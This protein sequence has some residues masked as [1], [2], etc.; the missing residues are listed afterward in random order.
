MVENVIS[1][2]EVKTGNV[3]SGAEVRVNVGPGS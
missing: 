3:T 2:V 1:G